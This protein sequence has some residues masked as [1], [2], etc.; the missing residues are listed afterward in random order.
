MT[1]KDY[2]KAIEDYT[3]AIRLNPQFASAVL[4]KRALAQAE[5]KEYDKAIE[6]FTEVIRLDPQ[7]E[8]FRHRGDAWADKREYDKA[9]NDYTEAIRLDP[10]DAYALRDLA[11][12]YS[13]CPN[14]KFRDGKKAVTV[15]TQACELTGWK[16]GYKLNTLAVAYA[17]SGDF[18]KALKY[19]KQALEDK[20]AEKEL[21][22]KW[23]MRLKLYEQK[24]P[25]HKP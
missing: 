3:E 17:E 15:A 19:Q 18:E 22:D 6:D 23:R 14:A 12:L 5:K 20:V 25:Y 1:K 11:W 21:G 16:D 7:S 9:I 13:T 2:D 4:R 10:K 8:W 24:Q